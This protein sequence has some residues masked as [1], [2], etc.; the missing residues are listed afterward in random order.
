MGRSLSE[1]TAKHKKSDTRAVRLLAW[2]DRHARVL[3]WRALKGQVADPYHV[4]LSEI[5][6]QQTTVAAVGP[7]F[8]K[9][10]KRWPN[11][12]ALAK[13]ELD[14][15]MRLWAGLGYYRRARGLHA[16]AQVIVRDYGG[17]FPQDEKELLKLPGLGPY[18]AAAIR[19][20]AFDQCANVVDGNVERVV[21]RLFRLEEPMPKGKKL[22]RER[23]AS[24]LPQA[25]FGD[26]AQALMDLGAT[27][28]TPRS[29]KCSLC[30]W[31][32]DCA[33]QASGTMEA[34]PRR[35]A[36]KA[37]PLRRGIAFVAVDPK[38]RVLIRKRESEG[39]LAGMME[40]P[41]TPWR[42][43][44]R[45][46]LSAAAAHAPVEGAWKLLKGS[47][48]HT[49]THFELELGIAVAQVQPKGKIRG[50]WVAPQ[51]WAQEALPS[52]MRKVLGFARKSMKGD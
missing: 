24:L 48:F 13:A 42:E 20:I 4:W 12:H 33:A 30:P 46:S 31:V 29:P 19:A 5:M 35:E 28:C 41:S 21:A 2:Y 38:G 36:P 27:V 39:L 23:A 52:V 15:V 51:E 45:P 18:T 9:F 7:Y 34:Y 1:K 32:K 10:L 25:R 8:E 37:R 16:C 40:V 50:H 3:P 22:L 49:F 44:R 14:D 11:I 43:G 47:I 26:Y 6:L 17:V